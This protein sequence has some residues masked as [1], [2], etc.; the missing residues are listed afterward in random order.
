MADTVFQAGEYNLDYAEILQASGSAIDIRQ[1]IDGISFY[2]D[3][4]APFISGKISFRDT[5]D[6]PNWLGRSGRDIIRISVG[7]PGIVDSKK[8][9]GL[10]VVFKMS[11]RTMIRDRTQMYNFHF[12][13]VEALADLHTQISKAFSGTAETMIKKITKEYLQTEKALTYESSISS[14]KFVSNFWSPSKAI[15]YIAQH[16]KNAQNDSSFLFYENRYGFMFNTLSDMNNQKITQV[17]DENDFSVDITADPSNNVQFGQANRDPNRDYQIPQE[18]RVQTTYD[19][20][21]VYRGG[22]IRTRMMT[23]DILKKQYVVSDFKMN[24]TGVLNQ[25]SLFR[26]DVIDNAGALRMFVQKEYGVNDVPNST[27]SQ[28]IQSR[29]SELK[30]MMSSKIEIDVFGRSDYTVG[31]RVYYNSNVK[32]QISLADKPNA[33]E[34]KVTSGYY[35]ITAISHNF[36]R[37]AHMCTI[38]LSKESTKL[39]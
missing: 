9:S 39:E 19:Y 11:D 23:H 22:G 4:Y 33:L 13:S 21:D 31:Q 5:Q 8:I 35:I 6:L 37:K 27:N 30:L 25:N 34:D 18:V 7:T 36:T 16:A 2:E 24:S 14:F 15:N 17:F 10:F 1:Q 29:I 3:I 28:I 32:Q 12:I 38:E 26:Q 20:M